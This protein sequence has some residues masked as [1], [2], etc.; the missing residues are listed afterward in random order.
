MID[1]PICFKK[2]KSLRR[3]SFELPI[4]KFINFLMRKGKKEKITRVVFLAIREIFKIKKKSNFFD[5][6][7]DN[8]LTFWVF[9]NKI[10]LFN[11]H[12]Q[13]ISNFPTYG[14]SLVKL[15]SEEEGEE[16][17]EEEEEVFQIPLDNIIMPINTKF[18]FN[19]L[20]INLKYNKLFFNKKIDI[21]TN[22]FFKNFLL[23]KLEQILP[24]FNFYIYSVDKN[25]KKYSRGKSGKYVFV[26]K[27]IAP[28]KRLKAAIKLI[29]K[30]IKFNQFK[31]V[32][33]RVINSLLNLENNLK[34]SYVY[35]SKTFSYNYIFKN[36]R[37]TLMSTL[38]TTTT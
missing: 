36:F 35:K 32:D 20:L 18:F 9:L 10:N 17:E 29:S 21:D 16:E 30:E 13:N 12:T 6:D 7:V 23:K 28:F 5:V 4:L 24:I 11:L 14:F 19:N 27:Y 15:K 26:W 25:I 2:S 8:W 37:K 1:V 33:Q 3:V 34:D 22:F 31:G 38:K